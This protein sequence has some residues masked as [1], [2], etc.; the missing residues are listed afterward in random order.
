MIDAERILF[1]DRCPKGFTK[2]QILGK[3]GVAVV[4]LCQNSQTGLKV[5]IK[6][7]PKKVPKQTEASAKV[8]IAVH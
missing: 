5:A 1:G 2:L 8:E 6:Q 4:W 7:F 3:G